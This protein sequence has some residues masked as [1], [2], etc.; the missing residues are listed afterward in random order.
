[1]NHNTD[2]P[3]AARDAVEELQHDPFANAKRAIDRARIVLAGET[4]APDDAERASGAAVQATRD[5]SP[6]TVQNPA[7][8]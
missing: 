4:P 5:P 7:G 2:G 3:D 6:D 8:E 1:V